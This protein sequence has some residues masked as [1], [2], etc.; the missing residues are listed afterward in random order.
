MG[1]CGE[2][3]FFFLKKNDVLDISKVE[4]FECASRQRVNPL[5]LMREHT[6]ISK[7]GCQLKL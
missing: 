3:F 2:V 5:Q 1:E 4:F 7:T 6:T